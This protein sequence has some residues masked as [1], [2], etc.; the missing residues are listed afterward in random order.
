MNRYLVGTEDGLRIFAR[1]M[2]H[3]KPKRQ[4]R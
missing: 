2:E 4:L 1:L 3:G